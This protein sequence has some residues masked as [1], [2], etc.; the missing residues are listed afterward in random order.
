VRRNVE[1]GPHSTITTTNR[2]SE[3]HKVTRPARNNVS[4]TMWDEEIRRA[5]NRQQARRLALAG[6]SYAYS[7]GLSPGELIQ[8]FMCAKVLACLILRSRRSR[9]LLPGGSAS[10][11]VLI[12]SSLSEMRSSNEVSCF[13]WRRMTILLRILPAD[14]RKQGPLGSDR[15]P[16]AVA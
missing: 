8:S 7:G 1:T 16:P 13:T 15:F 14:K 12:S 11:F 10:A 3:L 4:S 5:W 6:F 9:S 2:I